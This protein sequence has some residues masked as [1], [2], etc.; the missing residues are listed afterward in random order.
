M[1]I[2][3]F[4]LLP[5]LFTRTTVAR[6]FLP[7]LLM[8]ALPVGMN[9]VEMSGREAKAMA[10]MGPGGEGD[11]EGGLG[12]APAALWRLGGCERRPAVGVARCGGA[13]VRGKET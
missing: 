1:S 2:L 6:D 7:D 10:K 11:H 9:C 5:L 4:S 13:R 8:V 3:P 12:A